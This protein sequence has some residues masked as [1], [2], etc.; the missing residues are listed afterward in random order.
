MV[1]FDDQNDLNIL[2]KAKQINKQITL[3]DM[4]FQKLR[5]K[6]GKDLTVVGNIISGIQKWEQ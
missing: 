2:K 6:K 1:G 3:F 4:P 5:K